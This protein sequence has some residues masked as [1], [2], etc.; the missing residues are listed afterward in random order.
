M[1]RSLPSLAALSLAS[2]K[3]STQT[4][5]L[6]LAFKSP[7]SCWKSGR[8]RSGSSS[9]VLLICSIS[10]KPT[11]APFCSACTA[12]LGRGFAGAAARGGGCVGPE[13]KPAQP[14]P[15]PASALDSPAVAA[16]A[17][18]LPMLR[19]PCLTAAEIGP[20][21]HGSVPGFAHTPAP[22]DRWRK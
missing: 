3:S 12:A 17:D 15:S 6:L 19:R 4:S 22:T 8:T 13:G 2:L 1:N 7:T 14:P 5:L 20:E 10:S 21:P 9:L 18:S 11:L 16:P